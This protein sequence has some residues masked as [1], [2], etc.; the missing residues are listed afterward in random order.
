MEECEAL[1]NRLAIMINGSIIAIGATE[2]L[3]HKFQAGFNL[4]IKL[5]P[6]RSEENV[7][8]IKNM[9]EKSLICDLCDE[10]KVS[11]KKDNSLCFLI[12]KI[13]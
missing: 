2:Q 5:N 4:N 8:R 11:I 13:Q 7:K 10:H 1:C 3:K 12:F 6:E 9:I